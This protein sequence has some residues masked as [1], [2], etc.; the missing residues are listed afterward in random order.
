MLFVLVFEITE[1]KNALV[2]YSF[3]TTFIFP[4][5]IIDISRRP[6]TRANKVSDAFLISRA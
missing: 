4:D 1:V 6:F 5:S 2:S 3:S